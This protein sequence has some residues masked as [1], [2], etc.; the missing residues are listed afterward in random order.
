MV[1]L[2]WLVEQRSI[3]WIPSS[4]V[5]SVNIYFELVLQ[6]AEGTGLSIEAETSDDESLHRFA[7]VARGEII[8]QHKSPVDHDHSGI[9]R[10]QHLDG[11]LASS[12]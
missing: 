12:K 1:R 7:T 10:S 11:S 5:S 6:E 3:F 2:H 9:C 8:H 4:G